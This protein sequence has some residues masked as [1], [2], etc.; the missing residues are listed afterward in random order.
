MVA[1]LIQKCGYEAIDAAT[2]A[3]WGVDYL[4]VSADSLV[5]KSIVTGYSRRR[6]RVSLSI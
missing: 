6:T 2:F 5:V 4:K 1:G 3:E